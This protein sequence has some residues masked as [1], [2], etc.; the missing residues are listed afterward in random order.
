VTDEK[1]GTAYFVMSNEGEQWKIVKHSFD[2][3]HA[4][5]SCGE[6]A[7]FNSEDDARDM[8]KRRCVSALLKYYHQEMGK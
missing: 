1:L 7:G 5:R 4:V 2:N 3:V 8:V 6:I